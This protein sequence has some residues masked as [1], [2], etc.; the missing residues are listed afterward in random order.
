MNHPV[1]RRRRRA[2][3]AVGR[4]L[5]EAAAPALREAASGFDPFRV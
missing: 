1:H 3:T 5:G 2:G 4:S